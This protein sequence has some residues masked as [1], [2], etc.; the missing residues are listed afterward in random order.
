MKGMNLWS[1]Y[2]EHF[3]GDDQHSVAVLSAKGSKKV[4]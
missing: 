2:S 4:E 1:G 3:L